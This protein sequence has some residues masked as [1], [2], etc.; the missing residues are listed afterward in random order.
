MGTV[1]Y[2]GTH[3]R[4]IKQA[5][6]QHPLKNKTKPKQGHVQDTSRS[7]WAEKQSDDQQTDRRQ[8]TYRVA[9]SQL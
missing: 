7:K 5:S 9:S 8:T 4:W 1:Q 2:N 6:S 3:L